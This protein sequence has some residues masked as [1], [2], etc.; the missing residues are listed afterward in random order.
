MNEMTPFERTHARLR[1]APVDRVPN[2]NILMAYAAHSIG[3]T[4]SQ[5]AQDYRVLVEAS[6]QAARTY[7]LDWVSVISDPVREASAFGAVVHFPEDA[8]PFCEPLLSDYAQLD[9]LPVWDPWEKPRTCDRLLAVQSLRKQVGGFLP[10]SGW[11]EGAAA[12]AAMLLGVTRFLED[13]LIEPEQL[14]RLLERCNSQAIRFALD[15]LAAGAD[16]IGIGDAVCSLLSSAA[17]EQLA[18]PFEQHLIRAIHQAGGLAKLHICGNT[19]RLL[20][21][22]ALTGA[23]IIDVDWM[24]D[25]SAAVHICRGCAVNGNMDPVGIFLNGTRAQVIQAVSACLEVGGTRSFSSAGCEIPAG[26]PQDNLAAHYDAL[27]GLHR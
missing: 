6:L 8:V 18:L 7:H 3:K 1:G 19:S 25:L 20:P 4:Y 14:T 10:I 13:T 5:F 22:M 12:E 23:D 27:R 2:Q 11:V 17:Y 24:V 9:Q 16:I 21:L 26:C 15:Q